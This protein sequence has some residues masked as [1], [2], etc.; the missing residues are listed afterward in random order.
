MFYICIFWTTS[1]IFGA[2][3]VFPFE[4]MYLTK[5]MKADMYR[6]SVYYA[7]STLCDMMA[8]VL[9]PTVFMSILYFM[10][11]F[12]RTVPCFFL[13]L[14]AIFLIV[15]T[16]QVNSQSPFQLSILP[17]LLSGYNWFFFN[18]TGSW[19]AL[20][21]SSYEHKKVWDDGILGPNVVPLDRRILCPGMELQFVIKLT[22]KNFTDGQLITLIHVIFFCTKC[23]QIA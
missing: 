2:V 4:S 1:S 14:F 18:Q 9:Y 19:G 23:W 17:L 16:S 21:S 8:H 3:Y 10:A 6:L 20:W 13:T 11:D 22:C 15:I 7:C 12:K 5:D